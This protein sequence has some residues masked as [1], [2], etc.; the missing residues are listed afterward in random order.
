MQ[1]PVTP[2]WQSR[3]RRCQRRSRPR[4]TITPVPVPMAQSPGA[5]ASGTGPST[6]TRPAG[7]LSFKL[8]HYLPVTPGCKRMR[9]LYIYIYCSCTLTLTFLQASQVALSQSAFLQR[10]GQD[11]VRPLAKTKGDQASQGLLLE[12]TDRLTRLRL[13]SKA[14]QKPGRKDQQG[15]SSR[16]LFLKSC[17]EENGCVKSDGII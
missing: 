7:A 17:K 6:R 3:G 15:R 13:S 5:A 2:A 9:R 10:P 11:R 16:A 1:T 8:C 12:K 14:V 4:P